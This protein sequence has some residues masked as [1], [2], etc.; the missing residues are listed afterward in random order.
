MG[1]W[2]YNFCYNKLFYLT[3]EIGQLQ[4]NHMVTKKSYLYYT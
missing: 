3:L 2:G 4:D 1:T